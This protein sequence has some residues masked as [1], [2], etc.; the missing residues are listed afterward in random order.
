MN[1]S[2]FYLFLLYF[3]IFFVYTILLHFCF[4]FVSLVKVES[5]TF[6]ERLTKISEFHTLIASAGFSLSEV[7][8]P[9]RREIFIVF[10]SCPCPK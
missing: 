3:C 5:F 2:V 1:L 8:F 4:L 10:L 6:F 9:W 7:F